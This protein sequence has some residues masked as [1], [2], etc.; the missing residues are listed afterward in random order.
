MR[1]KVGSH[2]LKE[3]LCGMNICG[4]C[5]R[6]VHNI[7]LKITSKKGAKLL[8]GIDKW[9]CDYFFKYGKAKNLIRNLTLAQ[10]GL[11]VVQSKIAWQMF[12]CIII[13]IIMKLSTIIKSFQ[14]I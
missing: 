11:N 14:Q 2:I 1:C 10:I 3:E 6:D 8:Y 7:T 4:F 9:D 5:G 13:S 12:G